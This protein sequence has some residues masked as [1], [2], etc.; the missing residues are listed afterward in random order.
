[1]QPD[2]MLQALAPMAEEA[3]RAVDAGAALP[4]V[5]NEAILAAYLVGRG[6]SP[7]SAMETVQQWRLAGAARGLVRRQRT[8]QVT[9]P[10]G[11]TSLGMATGPMG[12]AAGGMGTVSG[13]M[14]TTAGGMGTV[15]GTMGTTAGGMETQGA[16]I[17]LRPM[18]TDQTPSDAAPPMGQPPAGQVEEAARRAEARKQLLSNIEK[19]MQDQ[20]SAAAFYQELMDLAQDPMVK[21]YINHAREDEVKHYRLLGELHRELTGQTYEAQPQRVEYTSLTDGLKKAM[22]NEYE[23][24][25]FYRDIYLGSDDERVRKVFFELFTDELE[26]AT[27]FNYALQVLPR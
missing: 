15:S 12:T 27:R 18:G 14:G 4:G 10:G 8:P 3:V 1:M 16:M 19:S 24:M 9:A 2:Q 26:H 11:G 21:D 22:N 25:E 23:A 20:A 13:P 7:R 6:L 5:M 17:H